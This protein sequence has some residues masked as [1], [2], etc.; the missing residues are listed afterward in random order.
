MIIPPFYP[1]PRD[2][3][4][5]AVEQVSTVASFRKEKGERRPPFDRLRALNVEAPSE[6]E[7]QERQVPQ[8]GP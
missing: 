4:W 7:G 3:P 6:V 1:L 8:S 5:E 2:P